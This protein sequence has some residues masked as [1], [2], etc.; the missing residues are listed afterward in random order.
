M[1][2]SIN[3]LIGGMMLTFSGIS[4]ALADT[5]DV[6]ESYGVYVAAEKGYVKVQ[7]YNHNQRFVDFNHLKEVP[8]VERGSQALKIIVYKKDFNESS[9]GLELR[10]ID[11]VVDIQ[12]IKFDIK[13]LKKPDMYELT[14]D[15][16]V[17]DGVMLHVY[18]GFFDNMGV[19]ML[20][21]TQAELV[22]YFSQKQLPDA[23]AVNQYLDDALVA[24]P[25]NA[26]L[27]E[28]S[29]YW[30]KAANIERDK[31]G[32]SYVEEKWQ[33]FQNAEKLELKQRYLNDMIGEING[34][35]RDYPNGY[36]A[37]EAKDRKAMA[38]KKLKEYEKLL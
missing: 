31:K 11:I 8:F 24:Y 34:Y 15:S 6:I 16:A 38:E 5:V 13:P 4:A 30:T 26:K 14:V 10:P 23:F 33:Q 9:I 7:P 12:Q 2:K 19:I 3:F 18:S 37:A 35:L 25:N 1:K 20:G 28:L 27:K 36:K 29:T 17:K 32:Y 21:N 22:K